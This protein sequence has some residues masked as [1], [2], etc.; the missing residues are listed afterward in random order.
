MTEIILKIF[1]G[2]NMVLGLAFLGAAVSTPSDTSIEKTPITVI[3]YLF[4]SLLFLG[5]SVA[6]FNRRPVARKLTIGLYG[7]ATFGVLWKVLSDFLGHDKILFSFPLV[8]VSVYLLFTAFFIWPVI[9]MLR[10]EMKDYFIKI[11]EQRTRMD[12]EK[13][14]SSLKR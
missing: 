8:T 13:A 9:F 14:R 2:L 5:L 3:I 7:L 1:T 10:R 12:E 6:V 11:Q 4:W